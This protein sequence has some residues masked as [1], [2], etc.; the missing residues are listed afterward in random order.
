M[1]EIGAADA[2][3]GMFDANSP[4]KV[5]RFVAAARE[6][7]GSLAKTVRMVLLHGAPPHAAVPSGA[8]DER[9]HVLPYPLG[10]PGGPDD[11]V[12]TVFRAYRAVMDVGAD[13][14]ARACAIVW[15]DPETLTSQWLYNLIQPVLELD[16]DLVTPCYAHHKF[17]ALLTTGVIA[18]FERALYGKRI[19]HPLGPDFGLSGRLTHHLRDRAAQLA[20]FNEWLFPVSEAIRAGFDIC[21]AHI[22][23]RRYP[24][25]DWTNL[26]TAMVQVLGAVFHEAEQNASFWQRIRGSQE[27]PVFGEPASVPGVPDTVDVRRLFE[28]F[29]LGCRNLQE[30]W[31]AVLPPTTMLEFRK[32]AQ[33]PLE[34]F[35]LPDALWARTVYDFGLGYHLKT[36][37]QDHL[38]RSMTPLYLGWVVSYA[39]EVVESGPLAVEDRLERLSAAFEAAK[40]YLV[41]RWRWPDR[42]NP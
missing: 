8:G 17:E 16:F 19:P 12:Q 23:V 34:S 42:F 35:R 27:V 26:S 18:P 37:N 20:K 10:E 14:N 41:S 28:S 7:V 3:I 38:L 31:S 36:I 25:A 24:A 11:P 13:L 21:R 39:Q 9:I 40:P 5:A 6:C 1:H 33:L 2:V 22:G 32:L 4:E 15:P 30:V 29:Q